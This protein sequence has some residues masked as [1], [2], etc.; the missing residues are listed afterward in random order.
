MGDEEDVNLNVRGVFLHILGDM[1]G[2]LAVML[3]ALIIK[4]TE[5]GWWTIH[6][7][8]MCTL[9]ICLLIS[10]SALPL[11]R[12]AGNLLLDKSPFDV[13]IFAQM[14]RELQGIKGVLNVHELHCWEVKTGYFMATCHLIIDPLYSDVDHTDK[15]C[16]DKCD[17]SHDKMTIIDQSKAILHK[18]GV[19]SSIV[20]S[21][22]PKKG[23]VA[24]K[25]AHD[26]CLDLYC[27]TNDCIKKSK[28][29]SN[30][31]A[32]CSQCDIKKVDDSKTDLLD[33]IEENQEV[34]Q[35][36]VSLTLEE[37]D[38][39]KENNDSANTH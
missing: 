14:E 28:A 30:S 31:M 3:S 8:P 33:K 1:F 39:V 4:Y 38:D 11:V 5:K 29:L 36:E 10:R 12:R 9:F 13:K 22:Y 21:E 6:I 7:D 35:E 37:M 32:S 26:P 23:D 18:Y 27:D 2:S 20:Q 15:Y 25:D 16:E 34:Y 19:H 24:W 17:L